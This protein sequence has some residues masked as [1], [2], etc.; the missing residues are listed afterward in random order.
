MQLYLKN[1][2]CV[3]YHGDNL[4]VLPKMPNGKVNLIYCD[5]LYNTKS[6][7]NDYID[8]LGTP[9]EAGSRGQRYVVC[10]SSR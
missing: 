9:K 4:D 7:F 2:M 5:V 10:P 6:K 3:L 8:D 1:N